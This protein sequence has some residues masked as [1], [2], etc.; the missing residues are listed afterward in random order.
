MTTCAPTLLEL[1]RAVRRDL[2]GLPEGDSC[3]YVAP[4]GLASPARLAIYRNT[5]NSTL[6][7]ALQL[8][9]PAVQALVGSEFFEGAARLFIEQCPPSSALLDSYGGKFAD[10]LAQMPQAASLAYLPDTARLEWAV[11]EVLHAPDAKPLDLLRLEQ[12]DEAGMQ[13]VRF[14]PNPAARVLESCFPVDAIWHAVLTRDDSAMADINLTADPVRVYVHR[15][16]SGVDVD[17][18]A[19]GQCRFMA[20]LLAGRPLHDAL[21]DAPDAQAPVWLASLF[22]SECFVDV[23]LSNQASSRTIERQVA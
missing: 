1:Q 5:A 12:L 22:A 2:L 11:N 15:G 8:T 10:F 19:E 17:R 4:D 9:Y 14:V 23:C 21:A 3:E 20:A 18:M 6:L 13:T 16:A 7:K